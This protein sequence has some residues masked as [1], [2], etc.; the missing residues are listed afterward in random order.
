M[1]RTLTGVFF[2][3]AKKYD[4]AIALSLNQNPGLNAWTILAT[5]RFN[6]ETARLKIS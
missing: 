1:R 5:T 6:A 3:D 2:S 4:D